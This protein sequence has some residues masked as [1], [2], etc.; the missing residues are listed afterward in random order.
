MYH[1]YAALQ[2]EFSIQK[3]T[4]TGRIRQAEYIAR[5][6]YN[7]AAKLMFATDP[8]DKKGVECRE[9]DE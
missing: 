3:V 2:G 5:M 6:P 9:H 4:K 7:S 1:E 8:V